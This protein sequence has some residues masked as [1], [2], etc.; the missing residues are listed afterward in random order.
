MNHDWYKSTMIIHC[1]LLVIGLGVDMRPIL[2]N[3]TKGLLGNCFLY[4][5]RH[6]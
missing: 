3:E 4:D 1:L 5:K 6:M 2:A